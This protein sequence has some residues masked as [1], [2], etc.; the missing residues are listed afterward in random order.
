MSIEAPTKTKTIAGK[1]YE[2][3]RIFYS[4]A[5]ALDAAAEARNHGY[6][7]RVVPVAMGIEKKYALYTKER[8]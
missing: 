1:K 5:R 6:N 3:D 8:K 4:E 2:L 7:A